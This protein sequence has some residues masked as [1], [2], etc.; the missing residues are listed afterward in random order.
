MMFPTKVKIH[1]VSY[2]CVTSTA[3][4]SMPA[5]RQVEKGALRVGYD[6]WNGAEQP[7]SDSNPN[8]NP[9]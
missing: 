4:P 9:T 6:T 5:L 1:V 2:P 8:S 7:N 3:L